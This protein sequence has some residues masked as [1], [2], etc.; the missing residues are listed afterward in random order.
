MNEKNN[1]DKV[2]QI[3]SI[4][5]SISFL[6]NE[7]EKNTSTEIQ[8]TKS[9]S[10]GT[11]FLRGHSP[12]NKKIP[13]L[14]SSKNEET[15]TISPEG[16]NDQMNNID[17]NQENKKRKVR[18]IKK[19]DEQQIL[20]DTLNEP[21]L[22]DNIQKNQETVDI[23]QTN[24][25]SES[26]P[27]VKKFEKPNPYKNIRHDNNKPHFDNKKN[28]LQ[29]KNK[30]N[31]NYQPRE[32]TPHEKEKEQE[33]IALEVIKDHPPVEKVLALIRQRTG[34]ASSQFWKELELVQSSDKPIDLKT[35]SSTL[36]KYAVLFNKEDIYSELL[37]NYNQYLVADDFHGNL[38][39][40]CAEKSSYFLDKTIM[41]YDKLFHDK[42]KLS[43]LLIDKLSYCSFRQDN[44]FIWLSWLDKNATEEILNKFWSK[45]FE[46][47]NVVLIIEGLHF[48]KLSNYLKNNIE[49]FQSYIEK[50]SKTHQIKQLLNN[51]RYYVDQANK[52]L[53]IDY[54]Q[55][56]KDF[57]LSLFQQV[58]DKKEILKEEKKPERREESATEVII[59]K[60]K[61]IDKSHTPSP[62]L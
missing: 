59:K 12:K 18:T 44:N 30:K 13:S 23:K 5:E 2:G 7:I 1:V 50:S 17:I 45:I 53:E 8:K 11:G 3:E 42:E 25:V 19:I 4:I 6:N 58:K 39:S 55:R 61:N 60:K 52:H 24:I 29:F 22:N 31:Y 27:P 10:K 15:K 49:E 32:L 16:N 40:Y 48:K 34:F 37:D 43:N 62:F 14:L 41:W 47:N 36:V 35:E 33:E 56:V 28:H 21:F 20:K 46:V 51:P 38:I 54:N 26:N 57:E 9:K